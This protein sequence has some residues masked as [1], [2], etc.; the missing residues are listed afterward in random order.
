MKAALFYEHGAPDVLDIEDVPTPE[1]GPDEVRLKV[2]ACALNHLDLWVR[3]GLPIETKLPHIGG[4][5]IAGTVDAMG[6]DVKGVHIGAR[7]VVDPSWSCGECEWC[8]RGDESL[9][10]RY[11][12]IG[13]H[14][15]GGLAEYVVVPARNLFAVP[16]DYPLEKAAAAPLMFMTAWRGLMT[17]G[18]LQAG[19]AVLIT[20]ASGGVATAAIQIA[21]HADARVFAVTTTENVE[22]IRTLGAETVYDRTQLDYSAQLWTDTGKRGADLIFDSVGT[23]TWRQNLRSA[24]RLGRIVVYGGTTGPKLETDVRQ[25]FWK[26]LEIIGTTMSNRREFAAVMELVFSGVFEPVIDVVWPLERIREAHMRLEGGEQLGKI[27][28]TV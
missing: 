18:R 24:A 22:R 25:V 14:T 21:R 23:A 3:R 6:A 12:I 1:P 13:E 20:G 2:A 5:D 26:Q 9:C 19:E 7:A 15:P 8:A 27:V 11:R 4:A 16:D 10:V 28:L 17:R